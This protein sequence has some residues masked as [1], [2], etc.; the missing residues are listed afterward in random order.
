MFTGLIE[1]KGIITRTERV[2]GGMRLEVYAPDFGRDMA[3]GDSVAVDGACLTI[4][5]FIRGAFLTESNPETNTIHSEVRRGSTQEV[6]MLAL[7]YS[8]MSVALVLF[9]VAIGIAV[10]Q[11]QIVDVSDPTS[12]V[13]RGVYGD[14]GWIEDIFVSGTRAY[15]VEGYGGMKILDVSDPSSPVLR[16]LYSTGE[17]GGGGEASSVFVSGNLA[18]IAN[19]TKGLWIVDV[20]DPSSPTLAGT[21]EFPERVSFNQVV[22]S[23][24]LAYVAAGGYLLVL[25]V[26]DPTRS[27]TSGPVLGARPMVTV[28]T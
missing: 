7:K 15:L 26:S 2:Q 28:D 14:V 24:S 22:V 13:L 4:V 19:G 12:P 10:S 17:L 11:D 18:Y 5:K 8:L 20:S 16:S 1:T 25:D 27:P 3:I 6:S 23:G 9:A 21:Y